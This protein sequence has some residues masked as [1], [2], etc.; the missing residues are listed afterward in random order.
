MRSFPLFAIIIALASCDSPGRQAAAEVPQALE[1]PPRSG[2]RVGFP[3][4]P[5]DGW[6]RPSLGQGEAPSEDKNGTLHALPVDSASVRD[7]HQLPPGVLYCLAANEVHPRGY[8]TANCAADAECPDGT[9]CNGTI[10]VRTCQS[11]SECPSGTIC[12][13]GSL[14]MCEARLD[15]LAR[16]RHHR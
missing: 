3:C 8:L 14:R 9:T 5:E 2:P 6:Q 11:T 4:V 16:H 1:T 15:P 13:E 12:S 7:F 10:C